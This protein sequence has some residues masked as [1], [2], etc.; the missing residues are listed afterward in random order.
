MIQK[1]FIT[2]Y[3]LS[4]GIEEVEMDVILN[5]PHFTKKGYRKQNGFQQ[6]FYNDDFHLTKEDA[7]KDAEKRRK[8]K[9]ESLQKQ[10]SKLEKL[11]F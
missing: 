2:K 6:S 1:A 8:K 3:A 9:I 11:S 5:D 10:I 4:S 7:I